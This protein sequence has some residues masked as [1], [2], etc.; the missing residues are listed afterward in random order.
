MNLQAVNTYQG[1]V[2]ATISMASLYTTSKCLRVLVSG[3][4]PS[5]VYFSLSSSV[6]YLTYISHT[7]AGASGHTVSLLA[8]TVVLVLECSTG[9]EGD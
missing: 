2:P 9:E 1:T 8:V 5:P 6:V 4:I 3:F 7:H